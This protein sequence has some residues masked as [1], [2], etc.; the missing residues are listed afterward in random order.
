MLVKFFTPTPEAGPFGALNYLL[1]DKNRSVSPE[2]LHGTPEIT[3]QLLL[4]SN[5]KNPYTAG[6]LS[7]APEESDI[8]EELQGHLMQSFEETLLAG[9]DHGQY[10]I[11]WIRHTDKNSRLE[12]NFHIVNTELTTG[13]SLQPYLHK[14]DVNRIDTWKSL[15][16][17]LYQLA[18]P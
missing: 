9:L 12:L 6:C 4:S 17:D 15:Q 18:D 10:D 7:F 14:F 5:S 11:C 3:K 8:S 13:K 16:N 2:L 1:G